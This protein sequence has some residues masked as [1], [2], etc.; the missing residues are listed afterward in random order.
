MRFFSLRISNLRVRII[1]RVPP[2]LSEIANVRPSY[3]KPH[4]RVRALAHSDY[5]RLECTFSV[6]FR[7]GERSSLDYVV[8]DEKKT[9]PIRPTMRPRDDGMIE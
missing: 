1:L 9:K 5:R 2:R 7:F 6:H 4:A 8:S 3:T